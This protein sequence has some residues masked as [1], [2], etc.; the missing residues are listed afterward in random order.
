M[1][2][3]LSMAAALLTGLACTSSYADDTV[4]INVSGTLTRAPCS[5]TS[6]KTLTANFGSIRTDQINTASAVDIPVTLSCPA[7]SSLNVSIKA[8]GV[9]QGSTTYASTTKANLVYTLTWKS[10]GTAANV[11][12]TKRNLTNQSGA[13][14]LGLTAKL[15]AITAQTEGTFTGSSVITLEYL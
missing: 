8:S 10:D 4:T 1:N 2:L 15:Y 7:N 14:N 9:Y 11:T 13:V 3:R 12:G 5:L 6:S